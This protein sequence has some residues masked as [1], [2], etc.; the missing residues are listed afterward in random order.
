MTI[1]LELILYVQTRFLSYGRVN[2]L[3]VYSRSERY[4]SALC[5]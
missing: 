5:G 3:R 4:P 2:F 1:D